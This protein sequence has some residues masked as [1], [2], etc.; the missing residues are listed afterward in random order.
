MN[1]RSL[2]FLEFDLA[3]GSGSMSQRGR[4]RKAWQPC[5]IV[6][7]D[8]PLRSSAVK[9]LADNGQIHAPLST[10]SHLGRTTYIAKCTW[11]QQCTKEWVFALVPPGGVQMEVQQVGEHTDEKNEKVVRRNLAKQYAKEASAGLALLQMEKQGIPE[12]QRPPVWQLN[13]F[14]PKQ[15]FLRERLIADCVGNLQQFLEKPPPGVVICP[16]AVCT[17]SQIRIGFYH[18]A[19]MAWLLASG[20]HLTCFCMDF[21][22][23]MGQKSLALGG[24]GPLGLRE[25]GNQRPQVRFVPLLLMVASSEDHEAHRALF[26]LYMEAMAK[27]NVQVSDGYADCFC[28][29]GIESLLQELKLPLHI[30]IL[31]TFI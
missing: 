5:A 10:S 17:A 4:K 29:N 8:G 24:C 6:A 12:A 31:A 20:R 23:R 22:F 1:N 2:L 15:G 3:S 18:E 26:R 14:R 19:S 9:W 11:C 30:F 27:H 25:L 28:Y 13:N 16:G 21:T 7:A